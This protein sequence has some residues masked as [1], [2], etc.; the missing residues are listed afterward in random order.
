MAKREIM[1]GPHE[2]NKIKKI[3]KKKQ[4]TYIITAK[5]PKNMT[6]IG[7][8]I[9]LFARKNDVI[10]L[11]GELGTG[12]T[13]LARAII[14]K[15]TNNKNIEVPSPAYTIIQEYQS[16]HLSIAHVD[17]YRI[18]NPHDIEELAI[19]DACERN[20]VLIEWP[21]IAENILPKTRLNIRFE[22]E[23]KNQTKPYHEPIRKLT[24]NA[25][26]EWQKR[27]KHIKYVQDFLNE[28][29]YGEAKR[30][31]MYADASM[32]RY[33]RLENNKNTK[34][35]IKTVLLMDMAA[36]N[37]HHNNQTNYDHSAAIQSGISA[38]VTIGENLKKIGLSAPEIYE[39]DKKNKLAIIEDFGADDYVK[40]AQKEKNMAPW[41]NAAIDVLLHL[42]KVNPPKQITNRK[43]QIYTL[44]KYGKNI[45]N[46]EKN[47]LL[48]WF[49]PHQ[50]RKKLTKENIII[51][52]KIWQNLFNITNG[53]KNIWTLRDFHA[54]N[55]VALERRKGIK[56]VGIIDFQDALI[57]H[58]A[59]DLVSLLQDARIDVIPEDEETA[60]RYYIK[61][62]HNIE[63]N[64]D[65]KKIPN[66]I[67]HIRSAKKRKNTR[68]LLP[69]PSAR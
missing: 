3:I 62:R 56:K 55:L 68:N 60:L 49:Y 52:N 30:Y 67:C 31:L 24:L 32:R 37:N 42:Y 39:T 11:K 51:W 12:K 69:T 43:G 59:Y 29:G 63:K 36:Q 4:N 45:L 5:T 35:N 53:E 48:E 65:E 44:K 17:L 13:T 20:L 50:T 38:F 33:E 47:L 54:P 9:A 28:K 64:F 21:D 40:I 2:K 6:E 7:E 26:G 61:K 58:P 16:P 25:Q 14:K 19:E 66:N 18:K 27:L 15:L 57:G 41:R 1:S 23:I 34:K 10:T 46:A 22:E 8:I